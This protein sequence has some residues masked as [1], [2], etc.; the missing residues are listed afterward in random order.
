MKRKR[1]TLFAVLV[2]LAV[3]FSSITVQ[4][5][6]YTYT[7]KKKVM[8]LPI[9]YEVVATVS[10]SAEF[11]S[12]VDMRVYGEHIYVLDSERKDITLIDENY[13]VLNRILFTKDS[14][15]YETNQL[16]G[17]YI[18]K[19]K[20]YVADYGKGCIF[21]ADN[22]GNVLKEIFLGEDVLGTTAF[23]P[24][25]I[26]VDHT[27][28][29]YIISE[30]EYRGIIVLNENL[31]F[32]SFYG[33]LNVDVSASLLVDMMWRNFMTDDQIDNSVQYIPGG[34][35]DIDIDENG[36]IYTTRGVSEK[37]TE[38]IRKL[39]PAGANVLAY[40][41][42]F[43]DM[44]L[45]KNDPTSF[46]AVSID[47]K[48]FITAL[49]KTRQRLFQY[50]PEGD[51]LYVFGGKGSQNGLF[52][53][54]VCTAAFEE[55]LLILDKDTSSLTVLK[56]TDFGAMVREAVTLY[57]KA[58]FGDSEELWNEILK[59]SGNYEYAYVGLGKIYE[60]NK[61]YHK[62]MEYY[63]LGDSVENYSSAMKKYRSELLKDSFGV[64]MTVILII[65]IVVTIIF[66]KK[67]GRKNQERPKLYERGK[68]AYITYTLLHPADGYADLRYNGKYSPLA[69]NVIVIWWFF[70]SCLNFN[71][72][73]YIF[74]E[75]NV[76]DFNIWVILLSTVGVLFLFTLSS[77]LLSSFFEGK[78]K[79]GEIWIGLSYALIPHVIWLTAELL[80]TNVLVAEEG[81]FVIFFRIFFAA[82]TLFLCFVAL[83]EIHQYSF[84]MNVASVLCSILG[85]LIVVFLVFLM[86]NLTAQ[87]TEFVK[88]IFSELNYRSLAG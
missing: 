51:L 6:S 56:P 48:G 2:L 42:E 24:Q 7:N 26:I 49:D 64:I 85:V 62:A 31:E 71:Y 43:G 75:N 54:A 41:E 77:V 82:W 4:A 76:N 20:F 84:S 32:E 23:K 72:N 81:A 22:K 68:I 80:L 78:G 52:Q 33:A 67:I 53:N 73:G 17:F 13:N 14:V 57:R 35:T 88:T 30:N 69:A 5:E 44:E 25:C 55:Q 21:V 50:S 16:S 27:G 46:S 8:E 36:F 1:F 61:S 19:D 9:P 47:S 11:I 59:Q 37:T 15:V 12:P 34:Y 58:Q 79:F 74:N 38:L 87:I 66:K 70:V 60:T 29:V 40:T 63:R 39:N 86:F 65:V 10:S 3:I 28:F 83:L 18:F 45:S